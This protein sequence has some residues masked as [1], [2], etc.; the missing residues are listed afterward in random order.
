MGD[1]EL[2]KIENVSYDGELPK[3]SSKLW[4]SM[5]ILKFQ[6]WRQRVFQL[7]KS[8]DLAPKK[9]SNYQSLLQRYGKLDKME[10]LVA[11]F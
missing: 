2:V 4:E 3:N 9:L 10:V 7:V 6:N 1:A 11:G 8:K 5:L